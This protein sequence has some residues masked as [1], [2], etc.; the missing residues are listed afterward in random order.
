MNWLK[1]YGWPILVVGFISLW[2][3]AMVILQMQANDMEDA[4]TVA[5]QPYAVLAEYKLEDKNFVVCGN[6]EHIEYTVE[7]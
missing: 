4:R 6:K 7:N 1:D 5:C 2:L 3:F